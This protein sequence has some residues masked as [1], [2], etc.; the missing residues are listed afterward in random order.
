MPSWIVYWSWGDARVPT[1]QAATELREYLAE[2]HRVRAYAYPAPG[3][4]GEI[5][6]WVPGLV[7]P[8]PA[9]A[10]PLPDPAPPPESSQRPQ[11]RR[12]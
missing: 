6:G 7:A 5:G 11:G 3:E 10:D 2:Y 4:G 12:T 8:S 9:S 1:E